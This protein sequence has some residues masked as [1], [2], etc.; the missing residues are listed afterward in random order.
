MTNSA[1]VSCGAAILNESLQ[2]GMVGAPDADRKDGHVGRAA[3]VIDAA[4]F[5]EGAAS[6]TLAF[7]AFA[8]SFG[9]IFFFA[10]IA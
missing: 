1:F 4:L 2:A 7:F 6:D 10:V 5:C 9:T 8:K 3:G